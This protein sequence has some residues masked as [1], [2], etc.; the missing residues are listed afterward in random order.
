MSE[1]GVVA[2][3]L[4]TPV[5]VIIFCIGF[6]N[7]IA[8]M[9]GEAANYPR[10]MIVVLLLMTAANIVAEFRE[11]SKDRAA[12]TLVP[13]PGLRDVWSRWHRALLSIL[14]LV[15][16]LYAIPRLGFYP[17]TVGFL[18][19]LLPAVGM[20]KPLHLVMFIVGMMAGSYLLFSEVLQVLLPR[21]P[22]S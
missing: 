8:G 5:L 13:L 12:G 7:S 18:L 19:L 22:F 6:L 15:L 20:R 10:I 3:R 9:S 17:A 11:W 2:A 16:Y 1:T 14:L 21:G 4:V